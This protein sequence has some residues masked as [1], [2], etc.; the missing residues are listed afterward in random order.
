M[1]TTSE[2]GAAFASCA[3]E[4]AQRS[5]GFVPGR[6]TGRDGYRR[7]MDTCDATRA[8]AARAAGHSS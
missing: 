5:G 8:W 3:L 6:T 7:A 1:I 4:F 2:K